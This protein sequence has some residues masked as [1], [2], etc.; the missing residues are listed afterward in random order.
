MPLSYYMPN[1]SSGRR[2]LIEQGTEKGEKN[3]ESDYPRAVARDQSALKQVAQLAFQDWYNYVRGPSWSS[4]YHENKEWDEHRTQGIQLFT[5]AF[6][7]AYM[8]IC[9]R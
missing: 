8:P 6:M 5:T 9:R 7:N 1:R 2:S 4:H 3:A